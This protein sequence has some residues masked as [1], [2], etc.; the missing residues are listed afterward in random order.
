MA[1]I[2]TD[3]LGPLRAKLA[4]LDRIGIETD[5]KYLSRVCAEYAKNRTGLEVSQP[6]QD[7]K[8]VPG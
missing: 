3:C 7:A 1:L 8:S 6:H 5:V 2:G 4:P